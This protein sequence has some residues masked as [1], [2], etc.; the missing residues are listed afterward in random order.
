MTK[1]AINLF[2]LDGKDLLNKY[3]IENQDKIMQLLDEYSLKNKDEEVISY[4]KLK[5]SINT[6]IPLKYFSII[7]SIMSILFDEGNDKNIKERTMRESEFEFDDEYMDEAELY[8]QNAK[9]GMIQSGIIDNSGN[10]TKR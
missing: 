2:S 1:E 9:K 6:R 3:Y 7:F 4:K 5:E 10:Y 8:S